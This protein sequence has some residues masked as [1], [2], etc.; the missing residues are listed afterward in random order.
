MGQLID[1]AIYLTIL[2]VLFEFLIKEKKITKE[3]ILNFLPYFFVGLFATGLFLVFFQSFQREI[4]FWDSVVY[5]KK[6][7]EINKG[8]T[9]NLPATFNRVYQS[10]LYDDYTDLPALLISPGIFILGD[11]YSSYILSVNIFLILPVQILVAFL[12]RDLA[13]L[14]GITFYKGENTL[15]FLIILSPLFYIATIRGYLDCIGLLFVLYFLRYA[16][17]KKYE[18]FDWKSII[19]PSLMLVLFVFTRRW[20]LFWIV[21]FWLVYSIACSIKYLFDPETKNFKTFLNF[22]KTSL[23]TALFSITILFTFFYPFIKRIFGNDYQDMYSAYKNKT[24]LASFFEIIDFFGYFTLGF[25]FYGIYYGIKNRRLRYISIILT[26]QLFVTF[27]IFN[28]IQDFGI[29]HN[30]L[31][32]GNIL[33]GMGLGMFIFIDKIRNRNKI[34][35]SL[36][37]VLGGL[38]IL[39]FLC[40]FIPNLDYNATRFG[41]L[42]GNYRY[43]Y[44]IVRQDYS[45]IHQ[46]IRDINELIGVSKKK[47]YI[48]SSS[49]LMNDDLLRNALLPQNFNAIPGLLDTKD[50]DKRDGFPDDIF[51]NSDY[52]F[53]VSPMQIHVDESGQQ[54]VSYFVNTI[55]DSGRLGKYFKEIKRYKIGNNLDFEGIL[56]EKTKPIGITEVERAFTHFNERY[57][58]NPELRPKDYLRSTSFVQLGDGFSL[59]VGL[60]E[61][62]KQ[63][64]VHPGS[65]LSTKFTIGLEQ[66]KKGISFDLVHQDPQSI[67]KL[68]NRNEIAE[69]MFQ[70]YINDELVASDL[71]KWDLPKSYNFDL[72]NKET[73]RFEISKGNYGEG[74][75]GF[76]MNSF[77]IH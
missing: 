67:S 29:H 10:L 51:W 35:F 63:I 21:S 4:P 11:S 59:V 34:N 55:L 27:F 16:I 57:P 69:I 48:L 72:T 65:T 38:S 39:N 56:L 37:I 54:V 22:L 26:L 13:K 19:F 74:Y 61:G 70:V 2:Y 28:R 77:E 7:I 60:Q 43:A 3:N 45:V 52:V 40:Y 68:P 44:P 23:L 32:T 15:L 6:A 17:E 36:L 75:D 71:V 8:L 9:E 47:V 30:F 18:L 31:F 33:I 73:I 64:Y 50:I 14:I 62:N 41:G 5:W 46:I 24:G 58:K 20:Y 42:F 25:F 66:R 1:L 76:Y 12:I 49:Y 53:V